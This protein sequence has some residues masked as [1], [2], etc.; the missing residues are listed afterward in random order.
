M[1]CKKQSQ[2]EYKQVWYK[3]NRDRKIEDQRRWRQNNPGYQRR[4]SLRRRYDLSP[5]Q[6]DEM[7]AAQEN[8]CAMPDCRSPEPGGRTGQWFID[9]DHTTGKVRGLLCVSCNTK[10]GFYEN[11]RHRFSSF[12]RYINDGV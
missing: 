8:R 9:H 4:Y 1:A 10:L 5:S 12:E 7:L 2:R 11:N 3:A 6:F